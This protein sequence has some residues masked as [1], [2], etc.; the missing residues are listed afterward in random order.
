MCC[1]SCKIPVYSRKPR[2]RIRWGGYAEGR[3]QNDILR[4]QYGRPLQNMV[5]KSVP[6][7]TGGGKGNKR[8]GINRIK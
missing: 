6:D 7:Q 5:L 8:L 1:I 2:T 4:D 3:P